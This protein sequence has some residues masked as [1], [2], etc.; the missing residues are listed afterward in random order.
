M[1]GAAGALLELSADTHAPA[2]L[3]EAHSPGCVGFSLLRRWASVG[4]ESFVARVR[5]Q[6]VPGGW[7]SVQ[8]SGLFSEALGPPAH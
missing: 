3:C 4:M 1:A 2:P 7:G 6:G 5:P 8:P